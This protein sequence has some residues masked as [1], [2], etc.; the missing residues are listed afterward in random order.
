MKLEQRLQECIEDYERDFLDPD[1][2]TFP[3]DWPS[4][5]KRAEVKS[6]KDWNAPR[7]QRV[8]NAKMN[9]EQAKKQAK[10][11]LERAKEV[12]E[13]YLTEKRQN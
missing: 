6:R 4:A 1:P 8:K 12:Y 10:K 7:M 11:D 13:I 2:A 9:L 3:A 5:K